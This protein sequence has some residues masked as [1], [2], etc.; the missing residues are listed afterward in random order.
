MKVGTGLTRGRQP[1]PG[2]AVQAVRQAM[3]QAGLDI[4]NS[5][6]L[7]LSENFAQNPQPA[8]RA[9]AKAA[10]TTQVSG[11]SAPGIFT[12]DEWVLDGSAA[13]A[14]VLGDDAA[15][16]LARGRKDEILLTLAAPNAF[17]SSW[18]MSPGICFGGVA[19]DAT[20]QGRFS[21][22]NNGKASSAGHC[23]LILEGA[24]GVVDVAHAVKPMSVPQ[25]IEQASRHDLLVLSSQ[26]GPRQSAWS[27][28]TSALGGQDIDDH[29]GMP[30]RRVMLML[31]EHEA[32]LLRRE[33]Q[34]IP[35]VGA[36]AVAQSVTLTKKAVPGNWCAWGVLDRDA[37]QQHLDAKIVSMG[38]RLR[39]E[40]AFGLMFSCLARGPHFYD[41]VD[42]DIALL[43]RYYPSM[44]VIGFYGN[45]EI[46]P[47][48]GR[49]V[50]WQ[51]SVVLG[52]FTA[53][54]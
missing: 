52:L 53:E 30:C 27:S 37:A 33:C 8:L 34:L 25:R 41:G 50:L 11:C 36:D 5:V 4:A 18:M 39:D 46:A 3:D 7:F 6:L 26:S 47:L 14:L 23:Q 12:Q 21:V 35:I 16:S 51:N 43:K 48:N 54:S 9:A 24:A 42:Q 10:S 15:I 20:G 17:N 19:G 44:P 22:W 2:L 29:A 49:N 1:L 40:P 31:A 28:L 32:E 13:A 45:G 38:A